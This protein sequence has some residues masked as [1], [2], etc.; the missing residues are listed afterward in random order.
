MKITANNL[1]AKIINF[2]IETFQKLSNTFIKDTNNEFIEKLSND[3]NLQANFEDMMRLIRISTVQNLFVITQ[4]DEKNYYFLLDSETNTSLEADMFEPFNPLSD[5][6]D[7]SYQSKQVQIFHHNKKDDLWITI[8]YPIIE[9][10]RVVGLIGADISDALD[11]E[12]QTRLQ[13]F[14]HFFLLMFV[15]SIFWFIFLYTTTLYFRAKAKQGYIDPLTHIY[16]RKYLYE[17]VL[18]KL[19]RNYQLFML[20]IDFFKQVNDT[21]G[22]DIGDKVLQEVAARVTKLMRDEDTL[23]R[24]GGEE[25]L[26]YTS[27]L[28]QQQ[29]F[30]FAERIRE[31]IAKEPVVYQDIVCPVTISIGINPK[32]TKRD[33]FD[34]MLKKADTALYKAKNSGRNCVILS[35]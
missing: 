8:A 18:K 2:H 25:F 1:N 27:R 30:E 13:S 19:S 6:W 10:N 4:D 12:I 23:I 34:E 24:F 14:T 17:I 32:A 7:K 31:S 29:C 5:L 28:S 21:Y 11:A 33:N 26:I 35:S 16:N 15:L 9:E 20:D 22:H 3:V